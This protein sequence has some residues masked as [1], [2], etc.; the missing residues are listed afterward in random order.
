MPRTFDFYEPFQK[1]AK[2][3]FRALLS[4][5]HLYQS[6]RLNTDFVDRGAKVLFHQAEQVPSMM[7]GGFRT[8]RPWEDY[9]G[10]GLRFIR[11]QWVLKSGVLYAEGSVQYLASAGHVP[12]SVD[13]KLPTI[14]TFCPRCKRRLPFNPMDYPLREQGRD[15]PDEQWF[16][17]PYECQGCKGEPVRFLVRRSKDKLTLCGRDPMESVHVPS[18][19]PNV[20]G[21]RFGAAIV[22]MQSGQT[23][24][25]I[26]L[27]RVFVEQYWHRN[28]A[29]A[30]ALSKDPR[31]SGDK[32]GEAYKGTLPED[33]KQRFPTLCEVYSELS[34]AM[35]GADE[36]ALIFETNLSRITEH[37]QALKL[38]KI[39]A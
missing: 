6:V 39:G 28:A 3:A 30:E 25:A 24:A 20:L 19:I 38:F 14:E 12:D 26:F 23:L 35:H 16:H 1:S 2:E 32:K 17:L 34:A 7:A 11:Q 10:E 13:I 27:L 33:F 9:R 18:E 15:S 36:S 31:L 8:V 37:F 22:A 29:V 4:E 5:K 21:D